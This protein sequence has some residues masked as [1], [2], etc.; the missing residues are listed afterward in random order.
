MP[1]LIDALDPSVRSSATRS[2]AVY[3]LSG[4]MKHSA[5]AVKAFDAAN[6]WKVFKNAL[7]GEDFG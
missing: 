5:A 3:A 1:A 7:E 2:K 6:G 4:L